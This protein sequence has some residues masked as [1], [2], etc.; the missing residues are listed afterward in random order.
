MWYEHDAWEVAYHLDIVKPELAL[1]GQLPD[2]ALQAFVPS[3]GFPDVCRVVHR[4]QQ[5]SLNSTSR[6]GDSQLPLRVPSWDLI[7]KRHMYDSL[8]HADSS[9]M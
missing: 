8:I 2:N 7:L 1:N 4:L 5:T 9:C 3:K 6:P